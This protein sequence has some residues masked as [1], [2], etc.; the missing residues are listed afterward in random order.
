MQI[1]YIQPKIKTDFVFNHYNVGMV[2]YDY[3]L[4]IWQGFKIF[5]E[6]EST[7]YYDH[8]LVQPAKDNNPHGVLFTVLDLS[9]PQ[10]FNFSI[11]T[12]YNS[13]GKD[14]IKGS[15]SSIKNKD[16]GEVEIIDLKYDT[17]SGLKFDISLYWPG[18][19]N[20]TV[21]IFLLKITACENK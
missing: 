21:W 1:S 17:E 7:P 9:K 20:D 19:E 8:R 14:L 11:S 4:N 18:D 15:F 13:N 6:Q 12:E 3:A 5:I 2:I 16:T 10:K